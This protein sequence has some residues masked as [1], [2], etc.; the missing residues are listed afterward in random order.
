MHLYTKKILLPTLLSLLAI[1]CKTKS[2]GQDSTS[3]QPIDS[4]PIHIDYTPL[5]ATQSNKYRHIIQSFYD[6]IISKKLNG[7]ML[8]AKN[9]TIL[10][11]QYI[12]AERLDNPSS[13]PMNAHSSVHLAS[14]SKTFTA[15]AILLLQQQGKLTINDLVTQYLPTFPYP[16]VTIK[17]LLNHRAGLP[18]YVHALPSWGYKSTAMA[19]NQDVLNYMI[20]GKAPL[21]YKP[22]TKFSY[23]NT[24]YAMLALVIE[25]VSGVSYPVYLKNNI[26]LPLNMQDTYVF[27]P[28]DLPTA[29]PSYDR[30]K[31]FLYMNLDG[32]YGDKNIYSTVKDLYKWDQA[33]YTNKLINAESKQLTYTP[34]SNEKP[35]VKNYGLGWRM[36]NFENGRK[37]IFH[38][39]WWHGN[40]NAFIRLVQDS[41]TII[42]LG[43]KFSKTNYSVLQLSYLFGDYPFE[44]EVEEGK[45][46][47]K[48]AEINMLSQL[49]LR[50]DSLKKAPATK[51]KKDIILIPK[52]DSL[53]LPKPKPTLP[54]KQDTM[55]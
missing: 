43:N 44:Y 25:Q 54:T 45:D 50:A 3:T 24:N 16:T 29:I 39:G 38:N 4:I 31:P 21:L 41:A 6:T 47:S 14:V 15:G 42:C 10:F 26:F 51:P 13:A 1:A 49:K 23:C 18:N 5:D 52:K 48:A 30:T 32:V 20:L 36:F 2:T 37:I 22:D 7:Q 12:G 40:N 34:Y 9:G 8:V 17:M 46:T 55:E 27:T 19:T 28:A 11:E 53:N 35:G 33:L